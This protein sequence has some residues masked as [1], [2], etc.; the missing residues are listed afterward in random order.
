MGGDTHESRLIRSHPPPKM[1]DPVDIPHFEKPQVP[2]DKC[3][4]AKQVLPRVRRERK[5]SP[6]LKQVK[7]SFCDTLYSLLQSTHEMQWLDYC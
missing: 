6:G 7:L 2:S 1:L 4:P 3:S 5:A